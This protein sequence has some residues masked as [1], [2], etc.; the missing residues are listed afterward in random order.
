MITQLRN[1]GLNV[2]R[3][4]FSHGSYEVYIYKTTIAEILTL[5]IMLC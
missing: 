3:M 2:V 5:F 4:N 1:S